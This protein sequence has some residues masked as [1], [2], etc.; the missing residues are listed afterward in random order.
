MDIQRYTDRQRQ[1]DRH[2]KTQTD[3]Q[4]TFFMKEVKCKTYLGG[5]ESG[6][7]L[8]EASFPLHVKHEVPAV[9]E[10]YDEEQS[11]IHKTNANFSHR[12][13]L[14]SV[15]ILTNYFYRAAAMQPWSSYEHLSVCQMREL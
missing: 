2:T 6:F 1:T 9:H 7:F 12:H 15:C 8:V 5:V 11:T 3:R 4:S 10:L 13:I 14:Y